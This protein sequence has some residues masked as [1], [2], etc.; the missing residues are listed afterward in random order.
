MR[1]LRAHDQAKR[2]TAKARNDLEAYIIA[3]RDLVRMRSCLLAAA[4]VHDCAGSVTLP[5]RA[6]T[7]IH[8]ARACLCLPPAHAG[9]GPPATCLPSC[10]WT[11]PRS[12]GQP[13][14]RSSARPSLP[15]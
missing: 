10:S 2:E 15:S 5:Q 8:Q 4:A 13:P 3:T 12:G 14:R 11:A 9:H 6:A 7:G 1:R